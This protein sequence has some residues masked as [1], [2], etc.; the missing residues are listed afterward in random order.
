MGCNLGL[1]KW[2]A[3][4]VTPP[5]AGDSLSRPSDCTPNPIIAVVYTVITVAG[6]FV[7]SVLSIEI[8]P[9]STDP[10]SYGVYSLENKQRQEGRTE[11]RLN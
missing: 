2:S 9:S 3:V 10:D 7:G 1:K 8:G 5:M 6:G 11:D 4:W